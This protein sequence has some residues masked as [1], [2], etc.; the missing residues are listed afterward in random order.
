MRNIV[1]AAFAAVWLGGC[2]TSL[3]TLPDRD[4]TASVGD[5]MLG[6]PYA[7]PMLQYN[8]TLTRTLS[9]CP[10]DRDWDFADRTFVVRAGSLAITTK[11]DAKGSYGPGERY[12]VDYRALEAP[13]KT[14]DFSFVTNPNGTLKSIGVSAEDQTGEVLKS[15]VASALTIASL[16]TGN[17]AALGATVA[18][19]PPP[20]PPPPLTTESLKSQTPR[21]QREERERMRRHAALADLANAA[22]VTT[23]VGC[24]ADGF[25]LTTKESDNADAQDTAAKTLKAATAKVTRLTTIANL[26]SAGAKDA[27]APTAKSSRAGPDWPS[28]L[29]AAIEAQDKASSDAQDLV[30]KGNKLTKKLTAETAAT[31]PVSF[32]EWKEPFPADAATVEKLKPFLRPEREVALITPAIFKAWFDRQ[33]ADM[34]A[35]FRKIK[36]FGGMFDDKGNVID[37]PKGGDANCQGTGATRNGCW[38]AQTKLFGLL[39]TVQTGLYRCD[40]KANKELKDCSRVLPAREEP[41]KK[42]PPYP[43]VRHARDST[44]DI[45]V[46]VREPAIAIFWLCQGAVPDDP[47]K[48]EQPV[49]VGDA[50]LYA[51]DPVPA[52]QL[53]QL[54][55]L[56]FRN[57]PFESNQLS[58]ALRDDGS[59]EKFEYQR[60]KAAGAGAAASVQDALSQYKTFRDDQEKKKT[61]ALTAARTEEIAKIQFQ[62]DTLTKQK[63]LLKLQTPASEDADKAIK[64]ETAHIDAQTELL[65]AQLSRIQAQ[66]ALTAAGAGGG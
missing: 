17:P 36:A 18:A 50:K 5:A 39:E 45:G 58:L 59:I 27:D 25:D 47:V 48:S 38:A 31:W 30:D 43:A 41:D 16:T 54:R 60:T 53:G 9:S 21:A 24:T 61:D 65:K 44:S 32:H 8:I 51:S 10:D 15:V 46:F 63:E 23:I 49:C 35:Q 6:V 26:K 42:E 7:L 37:E 52:P 57:G 3:S 19:L 14:S 1:V 22:R 4:T 20:P 11:A 28:Q 56:P 55:Y 62:I 2:A 12:T 64:D 66:A 33:P 34:Q 13:F 29:N 40:E